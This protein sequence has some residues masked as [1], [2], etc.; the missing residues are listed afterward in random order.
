M[1]TRKNFTYITLFLMLFF[2]A[3][4]SNEEP[5]KQN[6]IDSNIII[7]VDKDISSID[8]HGS[9]DSTSRQ[10][11]RNIFE[12]LIYQNPDLEIEPMLATEFKQLG[13][14][15]WNFKLRENTVFHSG[16]EFTAED[17]KASL[18][19]GLDP[20][21][22]SSSSFM[23]EMI[24]KIDIVNDHEINIH[25]S[26]PFAP[27]TANLAYNTSSIMSKTSI[28]KDYAQAIEKAGLNISV[29]EY[30]ELRD[31]KDEEFKEVSKQ[32]G[33]Y[34]GEFIQK[35]PDGTNHLKFVSRTNGDN[36]KLTKFEEFNNGEREF[37]DVT[38]RV[39]PEPSSR[40]SELEVDGVDIINAL[41]VS[42]INQLEES[43]HSK[44]AIK[45]SVRTTY[46]GFNT[47]KAPFD[48]K[49]IR[50]AI[51]HVINR[52]DIVN[53]IL[54]GVGTKATTPLAKNVFGYDDS[55]EG[56]DYDIRKAKEYMS[57]SSMPDGFKT[58]VWINEDPQI[59]SA[60]L[61]IQE[62]LKELN[63]D[64]EI[65]NYEYAA[66]FEE[67][68]KGEH[69]MFILG[70]STVTADADYIFNALFES[71]S[72]T[73]ANNRTNFDNEAF[74]NMIRDARKEMDPEIRLDLYKAAQ[75]IL[76]EESPAAFIYNN[77]FAIGINTDKL[78]RVE[79]DASGDIRLET[80]K[81]K[82]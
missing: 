49:N 61:Y 52:D 71:T 23:Y 25:T 4:C 68:Q 80:L 74:D 12:T 37:K 76:I 59:N 47:K 64:M 57:K 6:N 17:V 21:V 26:Y 1:F 32:M 40:V 7:G 53:G 44:V 10:V 8:P 81:L 2:I 41:D 24:E 79:V 20:T 70:W 5:N 30:Y 33:E 72:I 45:D 38:Y 9:N 63:I 42:E 60:A 15:E 48:D 82:K 22:A 43:D 46:L 78:D 3:A 58:T 54:E 27:L 11:R 14:T 65:R 51:S 19:R 67:L 62:E 77:Q 39:I 31:K 66:L 13:P 56:I 16:Q 28:D 36:I 73:E 50:L 34:I 75:E 69:D 18:E 35:N 29:Y 55:I